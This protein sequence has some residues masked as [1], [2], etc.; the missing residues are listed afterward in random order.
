M[1]LSVRRAFVDFT[2]PFEGVVSWLYADVKGLLT[3]GIGNLADPLPLALAMPW[4]HPDGKPATSIEIAR[5]WQ[6]VKNRPE[7]AKLGHR[8]AARYSTIRLTPE[9]IEKVVSA[10][11]NAMARYLVGRFLDFDVW[12]AD[13]QL[14]VLSVAW[15]CGPAFRFPKLQAALLEQDW[16]TAAYECRID[17]TGNPGVAPRNKAN[18]TLFRNASYVQRKGLD[19][20]VLYYPR[21]LTSEPDTA[22]DLQVTT[23]ATHPTMAPTEEHCRKREG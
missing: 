12:P 20:D 4:V 17:T 15:A 18:E 22:P 23:A 7:L 1:R 19:P 5:E 6:N 14:G 9:G 11:L 2:A 16:S 10:K 13:A 21:D 3:T 8:V